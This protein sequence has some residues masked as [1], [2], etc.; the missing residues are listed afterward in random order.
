MAFLSRTWAWAV[1]LLLVLSQETGTVPEKP[2]QL[3]W[4][5]A[6]EL[7]LVAGLH[8]LGAQG[9]GAQ[10]CGEGQA[11][12]GGSSSFSSQLLSSGHRCRLWA[13]LEPTWPVSSLTGLPSQPQAQNCFFF[14][15]T[16][17]SHLPL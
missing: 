2:R 13:A 16:N 7:H 5:C 10:A 1:I 8:R 11:G 6:R 3:Q 17:T 4:R 14:S 12:N 9:A 15:V